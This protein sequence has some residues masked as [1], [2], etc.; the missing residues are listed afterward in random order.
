MPAMEPIRRRRALGLRF[1]RARFR[2]D[3]IRRTQTSGAELEQREDQLSGM[4][5]GEHRTQ[6][7]V[8]SSMGP[9]S[10]HDR[11]CE[12]RREVNRI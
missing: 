11:I 8:S 7:A 6:L 9:P 1:A 10:A 12:T 5:Q 4:T 2:H 3:G